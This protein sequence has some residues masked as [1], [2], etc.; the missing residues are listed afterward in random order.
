M[1]QLSHSVLCGE[2]LQGGV[3]MCVLKAALEDYNQHSV[4]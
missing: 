3:L 4:L 1:C 2:V